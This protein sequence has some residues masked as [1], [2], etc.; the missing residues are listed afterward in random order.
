[1]LLENKYPCMNIL[2]ICAIYH[3]ALLFRDLLDSIEAQ[4]NNKIFVFN[5]VE[6]GTKVKEKF[7]IILDDKVFFSECY[8]KLDS[9]LYFPKRWKLVKTLIA[10][11]DVSKFDFIHAHSLM[12]N[13]YVAY[14]IS[15]IS[16]LKYIVTVR[17]TDI[18]RHMKIPFLRGIA[19][20]IVDH[21]SGVVF[22]SKPYRDF[23]VE[24][25]IPLSKR[26]DF[27][28]KSTIITNGVE[29]F[30]IDHKANE[31][32][33]IDG[34]IVKLIFVGRIDK[35]KNLSLVLNACDELICRGIRTALTVVGDAINT[36]E[37]K[38]LQ[39]KEYVIIKD[40]MSKEELITEY[41]ANDIFV[42][43]SKT[44][45]FGRVY[46]EAM[47]QG[48]PVIYT[49]GQGFDGQFDE[50]VIGYSVDSSDYMELANRV[51]LI[52]DDYSSISKRALKHIDRYSWAEIGNQTIKFYENV[53]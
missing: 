5:G 25:Y 2:Y 8:S 50:G 37:M 1:M 4:S 7:R 31:A 30:W 51:Q 21:A 36:E 43:P 41:R 16:S 9:N 28:K 10:N 23:Y 53:L 35:N 6:K 47:S 26:D 33:N 45:T 29:K 18:N 48:L 20:K 11:I 34:S 15:Q 14:K 40:F 44:E 19:R 13:G 12:N 22:L 27:L 3:E 52:L 38:M 39:Q 46:L 17:N 49:R 24:H 32:R 42:M